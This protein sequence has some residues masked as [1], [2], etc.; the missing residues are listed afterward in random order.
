MDLLGGNKIYARKGPQEVDVREEKGKRE[1][2]KRSESG[3]REP[4]IGLKSHCPG[5]S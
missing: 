1:D 5:T 2:G 3:Q 4:G